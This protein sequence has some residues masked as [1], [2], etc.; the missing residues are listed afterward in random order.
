MR[1]NLGGAI[2]DQ[3]KTAIAEVSSLARRAHHRHEDE[4]GYDMAMAAYLA[5][6]P[7]APQPGARDSVQA[8]LEI[9]NARLEAIQAIG[10]ATHGAAIGVIVQNLRKALSL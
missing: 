6:L 3:R 5:G 9:Q 10:K 8:H 7:G 1:L 2:A 4:G